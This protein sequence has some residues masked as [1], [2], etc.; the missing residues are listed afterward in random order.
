MGRWQA[1]KSYLVL[2]F[3]PGDAESPEADMKLRRTLNGSTTD[4][5]R[6]KP[7]SA[8]ASEWNTIGFSV[9]GGVAALYFDG[10]PVVAD[11]ECMAGTDPGSGGIALGMEAGTAA[12]DDVRVTVPQ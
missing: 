2:E 9:K 10:K 7:S 6:F 8:I 11:K 4:L 1:L 3:R 5:C 12:F